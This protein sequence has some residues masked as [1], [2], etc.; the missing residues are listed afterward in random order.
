MESSNAGTN[1]MTVE[2]LAMVCYSFTRMDIESMGNSSSM[3]VVFFVSYTSILRL[4]KKSG[5]CSTCASFHMATD[6]CFLVVRW[7]KPNPRPTLNP[8]VV[9]VVVF[10]L[11][12][13]CVQCFAY[14]GRRKF[15][16]DLLLRTCKTRSLDPEP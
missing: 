7:A 15:P 1:F 16:G 13:W 14:G 12:S 11:K 3:T 5:S 2:G 6:F 4:V 9:K 8:M 10:G